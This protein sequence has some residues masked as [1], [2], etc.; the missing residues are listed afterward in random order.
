MPDN[1]QTTTQ[2]V[3]YY[4]GILDV[5]YAVMTADSDTSAAAPTYGTPAIAGKS[6]EVTLTPQYREGSLYASNKRVRH[7][8]RIS[9]YEVSWNADQVLA[10]VRRALTGRT[11]D[12]KGVEA[13]KDS[14]SAPYV[15]I[16]FAI[17]KDSGA[18]ELWWLYKG[19]FAE[20]E[21]THQTEGDSIEYATPTLTG[22]FD[23]RIYDG[24]VASVLDTDATDADATVVGGWFSA[25]YETT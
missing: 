21:K 16:G 20:V 24:K 13:I 10:A 18:K 9:G 7:E 4:T 15:A 5:Y 1:E 19:K 22:V 6:I 17:T 12:A 3:G 23:A 8:R 2:P 25:V 11:A 14:Q